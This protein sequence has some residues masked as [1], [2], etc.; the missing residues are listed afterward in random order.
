MTTRQ[1]A[2]LSSARA[3]ELIAHFLAVL[4]GMTTDE[5]RLYLYVSNL[6]G[7]LESTRHEL[8]HGQVL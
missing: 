6:P 2:C 4:L 3:R 7:E 5:H 8:D 1:A